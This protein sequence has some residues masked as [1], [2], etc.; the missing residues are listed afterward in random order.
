METQATNSFTLNRHVVATATFENFLALGDEHGVDIYDV[1]ALYDHM[2][3]QHHPRVFSTHVIPVRQLSHHWSRIECILL[4]ETYVWV[5]LIDGMV[6]VYNWRTQ[7]EM[8]PTRFVPHRLP[9][10]MWCAGGVMHVGIYRT[11][12][13]D[14]Y[15]G[16][17]RIIN[18]QQV[19]Q[20]GM[21][22]ATILEHYMTVG[23]YT[24]A[25]NHQCLHLWS[26][27]AQFKLPLTRLMVSAATMKRIDSDILVYQA[28][29]YT[30]EASQNRCTLLMI[31]RIREDPGSL[32]RK[33]SMTVKRVVK[34]F[35]VLDMQV[36]RDMLALNVYHYDL[37]R[38]GVLFTC[39]KTLQ[40]RQFMYSDLLW[41]TLRM[42][43]LNVGGTHE[44]L[45]LMTGRT[46]A[47]LIK[48]AWTQNIGSLQAFVLAQH[49]FS[50]KIPREIVLYMLQF[51]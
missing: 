15:V 24:L 46:L 22:P 50:R 31:F 29:C 25:Y 28:L 40:T 51:F 38:Y 13:R 43:V 21:E 45:M 39:K 8:K 12:T 23:S 17:F 26:A 3:L 2:D 32:L 37:N 34:N 6:R 44:T 19:V 42:Q 16:R 10:K 41:S 36:Y 7:K 11:D 9:F 47:Q 20:V 33:D 30:D 4:Q 27:Q 48:P 1:T 35:R 49:Q 14:S 5:A 18:D